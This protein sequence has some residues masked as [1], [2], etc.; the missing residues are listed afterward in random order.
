M[1]LCVF[2]YANTGLQ[3]DKRTVS[4]I[5]HVFMPVCTHLY[6]FVY[7][8]FQNGDCQFIND[9]LTANDIEVLG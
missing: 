9:L 3:N 8:L 1:Y 5:L 2:L 7:I 4:D 6:I